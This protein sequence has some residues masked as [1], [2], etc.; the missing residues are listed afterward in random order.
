M[1]IAF[2]ALLLTL[3]LVIGVHEAGHAIAARIF[4]VTI[5]KISIGFGRPLM[6]WRS[7]NGCDWVWGMW[8]LGGYVQLANTR[9]SPEDPGLYHQC[10][11]KKP[12]WVRI[13]ILLAGAFAN[14]IAA[15]IAFVIVF[16]IGM[17]HKVPQIKEIQAGSVAA[18]SMMLPGDKVV[19]VAG[20]KTSSWQEVGKNLVLLWGKN[21]VPVTL[22]QSDNKLKTVVINLSNIPFAS[23]DRSLLSAVGITPNTGAG[24]VTLQA[25]S[26]Y[27]AVIMANQ[28]ICSL[29]YFFI[30]IIKQLISGAI[31]FSILLGPLG[32]LAASVSS[33]TQGLVVF[34]FFI[35][36]LSLAIAFVNLLPLP[37]LDG[38]SIIY[39]L[40]E[41]I[42]GKPVSIALEVLVHRLMVIV[43]CL[44]LVQLL[45]NDLVRLIH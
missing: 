33:L 34:L 42:R 16:S 9:I 15:W 18:Q 2:L 38:G 24:T 25:D 10:F 37:G 36:N 44:I 12:I 43:F 41:K 45:M 21:T 4:G 1:S 14:V 29:I 5:K 8:P 19:A 13:I 31:P 6:Q 20:N 32:V 35:A 11:D 23:K 22:S 7:K 17:N 3:I 40:I 28:A 39:A 27:E 26:F 30:M